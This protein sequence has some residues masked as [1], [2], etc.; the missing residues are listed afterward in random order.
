MSHKKP[1]ASTMAVHAGGALPTMRSQP[2]DPPIVR[3]TTYR[4]ESRRTIVEYNQSHPSDIFFYSRYENPTVR[5]V[6]Q[7]LALLE[8][9]EAGLCFGSGMAAIASTSFAL[10]ADPKGG[11]DPG[12]PLLC[13]TAIYGGAYRLFRD[14]LK[15]LGLPVVFLPPEQIVEGVWPVHPRAVYVESPINPTLRLLDLRKVAGRAHEVGAFAVVDGTFAPPPMQ[16]ALEHGLDLVIH[17]GTKYLG[18][19]SDLLAGAL[20]GSRELIAR[21]DAWRKLL[22]GVLDP[23]AAAELARSLKTL[24]VRLERQCQSSLELARRLEGDRRVSRVLYPGLKSHPDHE[25]AMRDL[26]HGFGGVVTIEVPGGMAQASRVFDGLR[27]FARAAS[28]GG[29]ESLVSLPADSSHFG[30]DD[31]ELERAGVSRG[32]LRLSIGLEDV[33]DLWADLDQALPL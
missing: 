20:L 27:V 25:L 17:S 21:V 8:G 26:R 12:R 32:M 2:L 10:L 29:V 18:G 30:F 33:E 3:N 13:A 7:K 24:P 22:G 5:A 1:N 19:H 28:L 14:H 31:A 23:L 16:R 4:V 11:V 15:L 9:A 6:E